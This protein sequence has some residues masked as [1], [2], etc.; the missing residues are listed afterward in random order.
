MRMR[1]LVAAAAV[2]LLF[3]AVGCSD[4]D[5]EEEEGKAAASQSCD[6]LLKPADAAAALPSDIP[7]GISG[8]TFYQV[9]TQGQ[10]KQ[11]FAYVSG[12]DFVKTRDDIKAAYQAANVE[13]EHTD[14]EE[15]EAELEFKKGDQ[16][17]SVQ[18]IAL[19]KDHLRIRYRVGPE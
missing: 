11:Y 18:V 17:G 16:A 4:K 14:Q 6:N 5:K 10:T 13:I 9:E 12:T 8:A 1:R 19:C 7:A 15:V 2:P 3:A